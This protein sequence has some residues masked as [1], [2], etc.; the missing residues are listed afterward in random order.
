MDLGVQRLWFMRNRS[1][2]DPWV[3]TV[4]PVAVWWI[5]KPRGPR[6]S[7]RSAMMVWLIVLPLTVGTLWWLHVTSRPLWPFGRPIGG[8][9]EIL[10]RYELTF[11]VCVVYVTLCSLPQCR[12]HRNQPTRDARQ[13]E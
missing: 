6:M 12:Y 4:G 5:P 1:L 7:L 11:L 13:N 9:A 10:L 2:P 3:S 8:F